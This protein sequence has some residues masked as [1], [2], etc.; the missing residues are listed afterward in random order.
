[1]SVQR[2]SPDGRRK[3]T[4]RSQLQEEARLETRRLDGCPEPGLVAGLG[5]FQLGQHILTRLAGWP[6]ACVDI[7]NCKHFQCN[8]TEMRQDSML[9]SEATSPQVESSPSNSLFNQNASL[10]FLCWDVSPRWSCPALESST[11]CLSGPSHDA[12]TKSLEM[13]KVIRQCV[14][15]I[16]NIRQSVGEFCFLN[17][18]VCFGEII[19]TFK[20][21]LLCSKIWA[22]LLINVIVFVFQLHVCVA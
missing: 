12:N 1:M 22:I 21:L 17:I 15:G 14:C 10:T 18:T 6:Q 8:W 20:S 16:I 19:I 2:D 9:A 13:K 3:C 4:L 7:L 11:A 5:P